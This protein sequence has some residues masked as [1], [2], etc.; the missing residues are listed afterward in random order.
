MMTAINPTSVHRFGRALVVMLA[1]PCACSDDSASTISDSAATLT[2][3]GTVTAASTSEA[4]A[5]AS[6]GATDAPTGGGSNSDSATN[7]TT[8]GVDSTSTG[9]STS[10]GSTAGDDTGLKFDLQQE[11]TTTTTTGDPQKPG[12][13]RPSEIHGASGG[14]PAFTDPA[15]ASF[16]DKSVVVMTS[17]AQE[18]GWVL[19]ILDI[20][21]PVP[22][23]NMNYNAPKYHNASWQGNNLGRIFGLT[24]D[25]SGNIYVAP[26]TVYGPNPSP[27]TIKRIDAKTGAITDF[28]TLPN[29]G[30]AFGNINYDCISETIYASNHE[31]GRIYQVDMDGQIVSTYRHLDKTVTVGPAMDAGEPD[32][33]FAPL[34]ARVW[35]VQSHAGRLYYSVWKEDSGRQNADSNE[36]WSV[37]Y[38][39]EGGVP[40]PATAKLEFLA[41][42]YLGQAYS[43][44]ISDLSFAATGWML[45]AQRTM[46][47]DN[48]TSAHQ[49]TTYEYQYNNGTWDLK[50][51]TFIIGEL[52]GSCAGG[53]DHDFADGGYVWMSG[54]AL[55]FY[56]PDVVYG[57]QG[58]PH[59]GGDIMNSTLIDLDGEITNQDKTAMGD[60]EVPIPGDAMPVP[61]PQ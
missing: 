48:Q 22:P 6:S 3:S 40:D 24:L 28:A 45:V 56:T 1:L 41:P 39:D 26:T 15:Y 17:N 13:C 44:P 31:D 47:S 53:V 8:Q 12:S 46:I 19:H 59:A 20:S 10:A 61:P 21:G 25:S 7:G 2:A 52:P 16:L 49:S 60:V 29:N 34:G 42:P 36:V 14:F 4:T 32:G 33:Q 35:A 58:T 30:P 38:T 54:D 27:A 51:T 5:A 23:P 18:D 55:D 9:T 37:A 11:G 50:G 57:L 43:N